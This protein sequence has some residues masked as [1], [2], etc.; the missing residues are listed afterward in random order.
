MPD[1]LPKKPRAEIMRANHDNAAEESVRIVQQRKLEAVETIDWLA[2]WAL[3]I[4]FSA[5]LIAGLAYFTDGDAKGAAAILTG[6]AIIIAIALYV[7]A[8][9]QKHTSKP[10]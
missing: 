8:P 5:T 7:S 2:I 4:A 6:A 3:S 1:R 10:D 9:P